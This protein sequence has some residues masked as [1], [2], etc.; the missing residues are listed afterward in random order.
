MGMGLGTSGRIAAMLGTNVGGENQLII[1]GVQAGLIALSLYLFIYIYLLRTAFKMTGE[2][3]G[4]A[5]KIAIFILLLKLGMI[6]SFLTA[7]AES[8]VYIS[9]ITWFFFRV[10]D[11]HKI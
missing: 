3:K 4:K 11:Q 6:I 5:R 1:I 10:N 8:Y 9:Y 7:E 2:R